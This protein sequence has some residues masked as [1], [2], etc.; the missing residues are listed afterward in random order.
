M[1]KII[2]FLFLC[3]LLVISLF[4]LCLMFTTAF[5]PEGN[6]LMSMNELF[7]KQW[8]VKNFKDVWAAGP[9]DQYFLNSVFVG[10]CVTL[11]NIIFSLMVA[12]AFARREFLGKKLFF[13][14]VLLMMMIPAQTIMVPTFILMKHFGWL[15]TYWALIV[16]SLVLPFNVFLLK[17][18]LHQLPLSLEEAAKLDGASDFQILFKIVMPLSKPALAVVGINTF[19]GAWNT[20]LYPFLLTNTTEMRTLPV[21]LALYKGLHG[22]DW[23]HLMAGAALSSAPVILIFLVFQK[24]IIRGLT[25][26]AI[27]E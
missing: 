2:L 12:Y 17:Q 7:P 10:I 16:P 15:N 26:G 6:L 4:P 27:K 14:T 19:L 5:K 1:K 8:T 25:A 20:F 22:V 9:F 23:V 13:G 3:C 11:G 18:Y 24:M 21:G